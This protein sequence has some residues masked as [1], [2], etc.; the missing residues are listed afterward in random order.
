MKKNSFNII[1]VFAGCGGLSEGFK[2]AGEYKFKAFVEWEQRPCET[3]IYRLKNK[4]KYKN[5][6]DIV[7]R[8]DLQRI[9]EL[10]S[11]W[12]GD[13]NYG[14]HQGLDKLIDDNLDIVIGGPPCQ[15]YSIAGRVK[16]KN[17]MNDDYRNYLFENYIKLVD[18][19][20]PKLFVF[21]NVPGILTAK[22]NGVSI[23]K[24]I[25]KAFSEIGYETVDDLKSKALIDASD[26]GVPQVR[27]RVIIV[28]VNKAMLNGNAQSVLNDFYENILPSF[29]VCKKNTVKDA[30]SDLTP[31]YPLSEQIH[32][33]ASHFIECDKYYNHVPRFHSIRD[34]EVFSELA[35]DKLM[36]TNK[37]PTTESLIELYYKITGRKSKFHKYNVLEYSKPSNTI[38]A[39]LYKDGLR[40]IHPDPKQAR[41][42]TPREA[43]RLQSF[44][45]DFEFK[46][47][48]G[49]QYKMIG[50]AVPPLLA[51]CIAL[52][53]QKLLHNYF[54][55]KIKV[56]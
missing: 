56:S 11:G 9:D 23:I 34:Q 42:I 18:K 28:G 15:A 2:Q 12:K 17:G 10:I 39:H 16:D 20:K 25:S 3:L 29:K 19:Y 41:T 33:K 37:Y 14:T 46:G 54:R 24:K 55:L 13:K 53:I 7:L 35:E 51:K 6:E 30:L 5:F 38:P 50:N 31:I 43:A 44:P 48:A 47:T 8:F 40:H 52:S 1:D 26:Y 49:D 32:R 4:W 21:E 36:G 27:K 22:P 45:D